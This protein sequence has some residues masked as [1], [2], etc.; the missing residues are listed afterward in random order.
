MKS[1]FNWEEKT[2]FNIF[3]Q[4]E[5]KQKKTK[6]S[7]INELQSIGNINWFINKR[8]NEDK[9]NFNGNIFLFEI[10]EYNENKVVPK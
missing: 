4:L 6:G 1:Y 5:G 2:I 10:N 7:I 3:I 9:I 8:I